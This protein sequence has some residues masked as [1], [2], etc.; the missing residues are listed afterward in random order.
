MA[1]NMI[2]R[3]LGGVIRTV[4]D[5]V[6]NLEGVMSSIQDNDYKGAAQ[7]LKTALSSIRTVKPTDLEKALAGEFP[8]HPIQVQGV[9]DAYTSADAGDFVAALGLLHSD[10]PGYVEP[11]SAQLESQVREPFTAKNVFILPT[12]ESA[13][14]LCGS[15]LTHNS[16][17]YLLCETAA[18]A[19]VGATDL[20]NYTTQ[21]QG[22]I[23]RWKHGLS[24]VALVTA[25]EPGSRGAVAIYQALCEADPSKK[26]K[27][28]ALVAALGMSHPSFTPQ[29]LKY[30]GPIR[31]EVRDD[32][33]DTV[34]FAG[35]RYQITQRD[36][37]KRVS[38]RAVDDNLGEFYLK[39]VAK[40]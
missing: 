20:E 14:V 26:L 9:M 1:E 39:R 6:V 17:R 3:A 7:Q 16:H 11:F 35:K 36:T 24:D 21:G 15:I 13:R 4:F 38:V 23:Q 33:Q 29:N 34:D 8:D 12:P 2:Q 28:K 31:L 37:P 10:L 40:A 30:S 19:R 5:G 25:Y 27:Q 32:N 18:W 22:M